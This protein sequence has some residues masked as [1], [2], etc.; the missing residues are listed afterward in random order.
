MLSHIDTRRLMLRLRCLPPAADA[1]A[2]YAD[3]CFSCAMPFSHSFD[4]AARMP[5]PRTEHA[6]PPLTA[7]IALFR[8]DFHT[9]FSLPLLRCLLF[10]A[11]P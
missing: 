7:M 8:D 9:T 6:M 11:M 2:A 10:H 3:V 4:A 5:R 1:I